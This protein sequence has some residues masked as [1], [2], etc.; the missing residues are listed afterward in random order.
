MKQAIFGDSKVDWERFAD[1][2]MRF[3]IGFH[4]RWV[5]ENKR[6][7]KHV[8]NYSSLIQNPFSTFK[9]IVTFLSEGGREVDEAKIQNIVDD[10]VIKKQTDFLQFEYYNE[11][12]FNKLRKMVKGIPGVNIKEDILDI[13]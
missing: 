7:N 10:R 12:F 6:A 9:D 5:L 3:W 1:E 13:I 8:V 11:K 4:E 2:K